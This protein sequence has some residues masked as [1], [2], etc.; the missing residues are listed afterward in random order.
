MKYVMVSIIIPVYNCEAYIARCLNS[1][2]GQ[3][4]GNIEILIIDDGSTDKTADICRSFE[5]ADERIRL[6]CKENAG[7]ASAR[8]MGLDLCRGEYVTFVD[9]DD[10]VRE[11]HIELLLSEVNKSDP[12]ISVI[13]YKTV[14]DTNVSEKGAMNASK[15]EVF[16]S[17]EA[18]RAL[19][20]MDKFQGMAWGKLYRKKLFEGIRFSD[21]KCYEDISVMLPL[22]EKCKRVAFISEYTYYYFQRKESLVNSKYSHQKLVLMS[23]AA[24]WVR[25]S[26]KKGDIYYLETGAFYLKSILTLLLNINDGDKSDYKADEKRL[27]RALRYAIR[28]LKG[29]P[30]I[31][32]RKKMLIA[33]FYIGVPGK[34]IA[35]AWRVWMM[36]KSGQKELF[37]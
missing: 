29:N 6:V 11:D 21:R 27:M 7:P 19:F 10:W 12:D 34:L 28:Y 20:R 25:Y 18:V 5:K 32:K 22:F 9:S 15:T 33:A 1:L 35:F 36:F 8:N 30:Y 24:Q 31:D 3:T 4:Y 37:A 16:N 2:C 26:Q 13:A 23:C 14:Y 17:D